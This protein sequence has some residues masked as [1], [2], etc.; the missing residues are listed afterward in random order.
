MQKIEVYFKDYAAYHK[1][2]G[3][4]ACHFVGIPLI[5]V[6]LFGL[7][8]HLAHFYPALILWLAAG[9]FYLKLHLRLG[10]AM[11]LATGALYVLGTLLPSSILWTIFVLGWVFQLVGHYR[12]ERKSPAFLNNLTHILVG[13]AFILNCLVRVYR[14]DAAPE[15]RS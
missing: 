13:P 14:S 5:V 2:R 4:K 1:T 11:L 3:N 12:Y 15:S 7:L 8:D 9:V 10:I 6:S